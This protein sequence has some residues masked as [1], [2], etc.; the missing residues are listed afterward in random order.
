M[1]LFS[2]FLIVIAVIFTLGCSAEDPICTTNFCAVGEI[3]PRSELEEGQAFSEV[4]IDDSV[5]FATLAGTTPTPVEPEP[6]EPEPTST[7][8]FADI[9]ADVAAGSRTYVGKTVSV[10][11]SVNE[12]TSNFRANDAITLQTNNDD[13]WFFVLSRNAPEKLQGYEKG[14]SYTFKVFIVDVDP[15]EPLSPEYDI[16]SYLPLETVSTTMNTIVADVAA[17]GTAYLQKTVSIRATVRADTQVFFDE[18]DDYETIALI[19]NDENVTFFVHNERYPPAELAQYEKDSTYDF[20]LFIYSI[21]D[22]IVSDR[23]FISAVVVLD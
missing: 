9:V 14:Q 6:V 7:V 19:T 22:S 11:A 15:P 13:V 5:I 20:K 3:F 21:G 12:D 2:S 23:K 16:W 17:G 8:T 18:D 4:N 10:T 1:R